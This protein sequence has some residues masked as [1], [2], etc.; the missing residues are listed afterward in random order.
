[1]LEQQGADEFRARAYRRAAESIAGYPQDLRELADLE[2]ADALLQIPGV[3]KGIASALSELLATG[4][5]SLLD[6]LRGTL[7]PE[8]LFVTVPGVGPQLAHKLHEALQ[9]DN[10][11]GLEAAAYD[12]RLAAV[13]GIGPRRISANRAGLSTRLGRLRRP[14]PPPGSMR[15]P[16]EL[17]LAI[18]RNYRE[19]AN[20]GSLPTIAPRRFNPSGEACLP[21]QHATHRGWH[22][23]ALYSNTARAH[24]LGRTRDWVVIYYYDHDHNERQCTVVTEHAGDLTGRRVVRGRESECRQ[25]YADA[26]DARDAHATR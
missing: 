11:E 7:D 16:V 25:Y 14:A 18:D 2:G 3:G 12:G 23:T 9:V 5:W 19:A 17:L 1:M 22:F 8:S 21:V 6:R 10:L 26:R 20:T 13:P 24:D 4:R 15:P